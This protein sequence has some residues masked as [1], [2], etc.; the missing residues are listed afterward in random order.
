MM[1][2]VRGG[3]LLLGGERGEVLGSRGRG[4]FHDYG[5]GVG[6]GWEVPL[7][8]YVSMWIFS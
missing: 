1:R 4:F 8:T 2:I 3:F 7:D 5:W 6:S